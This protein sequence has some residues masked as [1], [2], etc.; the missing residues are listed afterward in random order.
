MKLEIRDIVIAKT[1]YHSPGSRQKQPFFLVAKKSKAHSR[2]LLNYRK[3]LAIYAS[4]K[5]LFF[6]S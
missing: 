6:Q 5:I 1:N 4:L 2:D 3:Y